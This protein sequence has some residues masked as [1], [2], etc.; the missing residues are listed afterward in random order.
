MT[1]MN[2]TMR[3]HD[4]AAYR[5]ISKTLDTVFRKHGSKALT[6]IN[7]YLRVR[8]KTA[9]KEDRIS[10]LEGELANLKKVE[11]VRKA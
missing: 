5:E 8:R 4:P 1:L 11:T 10:E 9:Q 7:R 3:R 6:C 2:K